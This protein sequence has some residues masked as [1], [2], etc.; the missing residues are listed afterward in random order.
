[1]TM[2]ERDLENWEPDEG[3]IEWAQRFF[4]NM[5]MGGIWQP[6]GSGVS[7]KKTSEETWTVLRIIE[8]PI[9]TAHHINFK[10]LFDA[11]QVKIL[12]E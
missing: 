8:H 11:I 9:A 12:D 7:Y 6:E 1:M 5:P 4:D 3:M 2:N 10:K